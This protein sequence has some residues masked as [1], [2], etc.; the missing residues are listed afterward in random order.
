M[1]RV[2][3]GTAQ[4]RIGLIGKITVYNVKAFSIFSHVAQLKEPLNFELVSE[5]VGTQILTGAP[6]WSL[7]PLMLRA[8]KKLKFSAQLQDLETMSFAAR[9]RSACKSASFFKYQR[10]FEDRLFF[11]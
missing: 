1:F 3:R 10:F 7:S 11:K 8:F 2:V 5:R 9:F 6:F 4:L